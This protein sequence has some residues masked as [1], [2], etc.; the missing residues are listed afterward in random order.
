MEKNIPQ[1]KEENYS[2]ELVKKL[3][4][5]TIQNGWNSENVN[6][7]RVVWFTANGVV[8]AMTFIPN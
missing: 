7:G 6:K 3:Q 8:T 4:E 5:K 2:A 1:D